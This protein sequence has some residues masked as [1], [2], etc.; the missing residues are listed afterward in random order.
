[1]GMSPS[2]VRKLPRQAGL[3]CRSSAE[4]IVKK[5]VPK[6][7][8]KADIICIQRAKMESVE[9][10]KGMSIFMDV[11]WTSYGVFMREIKTFI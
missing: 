7:P 8:E 10:E 3:P 6:L 11:S 2:R 9:T 5:V 4:S 1:M